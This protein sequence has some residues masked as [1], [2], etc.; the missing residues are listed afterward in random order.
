MN[1]GDKADIVW[2]FNT[3]IGNDDICAL[4]W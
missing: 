1:I 4:W 3:G 2:L